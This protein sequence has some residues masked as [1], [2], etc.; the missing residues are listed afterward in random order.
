MAP[1]KLSA[2]KLDRAFLIAIYA[3]GSIGLLELVAGIRLLFV[4]TAQVNQAARLFAAHALDHDRDDFLF[5]FLAN[6]FAHLA[7]G[8]I[9]FAAIYLIIDSSIKL[10]L[11]YQILHKRYWA[12][13]ALIGVLSALSLYQIYRIANTHSPLLIALTLLDVLVIY[14]SA[15]EYLRHR[16]QPSPGASD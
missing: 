10:V 14:L 13:L 7:G 12:Y 6:Y 5:Q 3:K 1:P 4:R 9:R 16:E 8:T 11:I 15:K 2:S